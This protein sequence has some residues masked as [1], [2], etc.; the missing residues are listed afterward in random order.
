MA[1]HTTE[2]QPGSRGRGYANVMGMEH[3][4][5]VVAVDSAF[6]ILAWL[7]GESRIGSRLPPHLVLEFALPPS[8]CPAL[9][10]TEVPFNSYKSAHASAQVS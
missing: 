7:A 3:I 1:P 4:K 5:Y 2:V 10:Q 6:I 9:N 8:L